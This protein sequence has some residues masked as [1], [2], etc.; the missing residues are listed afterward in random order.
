MALLVAALVALCVL[1]L[2]RPAALWAH[3]LDPGVVRVFKRITVLGGSGPYLIATALLAPL[4]HWRLRRPLA[5]RRA[6][7]VFAAVAVSGLATDLAKVLFGRWRPKALLEQAAYGF[8]PLSYGYQHNSFPSGHATTAGALACALTLLF[9]RWR[10]LWFGAAAVVAASRVLVGAHY[11]GDVMAGF[12]FGAVLAL[13]LAGTRWFRAAL[14]AP[15][16]APP[17]DGN[18]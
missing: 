8:E 6:L 15:G 5:A 3:G 11:P 7:F 16:G 14:A 1:Y 9:P 18:V 12:W 13:A 4:L 17:R 2:D 10:V